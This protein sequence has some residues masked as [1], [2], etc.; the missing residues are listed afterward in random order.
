ME[1][2]LLPH[3]RQVP[4]WVEWDGRAAAGAAGAAPAAA[5]ATAEA[6]AGSVAGGG[7]RGPKAREAAAGTAAAAAAAEL[8]RFQFWLPAAGAP[9]HMAYYSCNGFSDSE[10]AHM[11]IPGPPLAGGVP[12]CGPV[13]A[14]KR[15]NPGPSPNCHITLVPRTSATSPWFAFLSTCPTPHP[16]HPGAPTHPTTA[17][18]L[19]N[20]SERID[21][22][23]L[24]RDLLGVHSAFPMHVLIGG[25]DRDTVY[26]STV[27]FA[28]AC[29]RLSLPGSAPAPQ[30]TFGLAKPKIDHW[31]M[32]S[33]CNARPKSSMFMPAAP[34]PAGDQVYCDDAWKAPALSEWAAIES[35]WEGENCVGR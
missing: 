3:Q 6:A 24:W 27:A 29:R 26:N 32:F 21:A 35:R 10:C 30:P 22:N 9:F 20:A 28:M 13:A 14:S 31:C 25:G 16:Q 18:V 5:A 1:F 8:E 17:D 7:G 19:P 33:T 23:Y 4:Y 34:S 2:E 12:R 11:H 15:P